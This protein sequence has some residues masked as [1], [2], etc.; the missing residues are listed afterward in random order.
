LGISV[1]M[2][3]AGAAYH[4]QVLGAFRDVDD[5]LSSLRLLSDHASAQKLAVDAATARPRCPIRVIATA[6]SVSSSCSTR[7]APNSRTGVSQCRSAGC[8]MTRRLAL[9]RA[10]GGGWKAVA[11]NRACV[12]MEPVSKAG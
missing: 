9:I 6:W 8:S 11:P 12:Q 10:L 3:I 5:Q 7:D 4:E 2:D 1:S